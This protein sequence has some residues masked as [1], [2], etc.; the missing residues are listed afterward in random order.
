MIKSDYIKYFL[1]NILE[2]RLQ[3]C[4]LLHACTFQSD[5][6]SLLKP[7][8]GGIKNFQPIVV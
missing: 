6:L 2:T 3:Y 5:L 4:A 8:V 1:L 7:G